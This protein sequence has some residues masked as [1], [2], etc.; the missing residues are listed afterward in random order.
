MKRV[1]HIRPSIFSNK[2][3]E[4]VMHGDSGLKG[5]VVDQKYKRP[6]RVYGLSMTSSFAPF[7]ERLTKSS[8]FKGGHTLFPFLLVEAKSEKSASGFEQ[9]ERQTA[10]SIRTCLKL[11]IDLETQSNQVLDPVVWFFGF[12]G[13]EWRLYL[14]FMV[15]DETV[16]RQS[17]TLVVLVSLMIAEGGRLLA[18]IRPGC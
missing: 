10:L 14:A 18:R 8:P 7:R 16:G 11:Q 9:I 6:D 2:S 13:D 12:M 3:D 15:G 5:E 17:S 1:N 4:R